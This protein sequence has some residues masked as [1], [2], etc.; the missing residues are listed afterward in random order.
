[1]I[2]ASA[3]DMGLIE[4][5]AFDIRMEFIRTPGGYPQKTPGGSARSF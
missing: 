5:S 2:E 1:V 3:F 4:A